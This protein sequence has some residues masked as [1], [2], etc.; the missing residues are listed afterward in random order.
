[1]LTVSRIARRL[2][3]NLIGAL[4]AALA[5]DSAQAAMLLSPTGP[6][7]F[8][9]VAVGATATKTLTLTN[10]GSA[11]VPIRGIEGLMVPGPITQTNTCGTALAANATCQI[12]LTFAPTA[13]DANIG[14]TVTM[15]LKVNADV[16]VD[17]SPY[18]LTGSISSA[19]TTGSTTPGGTDGQAMLILT[20][21]GPLAFGTVLNG[22]TETRLLNLTNMGFVDATSISV[23]ALS[24]PF[25]LRNGCGATLAPRSACT[26][27]VIY[28]PNDT[29]P[30]AAKASVTVNASVAVGGSPYAVTATSSSAG[31]VGLAF[32]PAGSFN[33]GSVKVGTTST[34]TLTLRNSAGTAATINNIPALTPPFG[35]TNNCPAKLAPGGSCQVKVSYTPTAAEFSTGVPSSTNLLVDASPAIAAYGLQGGPQTEKAILTLAPAGPFDFGN[36][37]GGQ[38]SRKTFTISNTGTETAKVTDV[39][40]EPPFSILPDSCHD[41]FVPPGQSCPIIVQYNPGGRE[42]EL[43]GPLTG[44]VEAFASTVIVNAPLTV[45][46]TA[47]GGDANLS[48]NPSGPFQFGGVRVGEIGNRVLRLS[49]YGG[50]AA[51]ITGFTGLSKPYSVSHNCSTSLRAGGFCDVTVSFAPTAADIG[52]ATSAQGTLT[53]SA[54]SAVTNSPYLFTA[55]P[56][57]AQAQT[58]TLALSPA[59]P[60]SFG[61]VPAGK[62]VTTKVTLTNSGSASAQIFGFTGLSA[63]FSVDSP[64]PTFL[65][66]GGSCEVKLTYAPLLT[67]ATGGAASASLAVAASVVVSGSPLALTATPQTSTASDT[68]TAFSFDAAR[69]VPLNIPVQSNAVTISGITRTVPVRIS[70]GT[71][72]INGQAYTADVSAARPGDTIKVRVS[73]STDYSTPVTATLKVGTVS[74]DFVVT[75]QTQTF[76]L[77]GTGISP[78][79]VVVQSTGTSSKQTLSLQLTLGDVISST[80]SSQA[81]RDGKFAASADYKLYVAA[82][83]PAGTLGLA[84][85]TFFTR[86]IK[87]NY[88]IAS[89]PLA[90]YLENVQLYSQDTAVKLDILSDLDFGLISGTEFYIGYG[91]SDGE[92]ITSKRFRAFYKVP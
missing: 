73:S 8:G 31:A 26:I 16:A 38:T 47:V 60:Y 24:A 45:T 69:G 53:V 42:V 28:A 83:T 54:S 12:S 76:V 22:Q 68:P 82:L 7:D 39:H 32:T 84:N 3:L 4:L 25:T 51:S 37:A 55:D 19:T 72:S 1:M 63:P 81:V 46:G 57:T 29:T 21:P 14:S 2:P 85:P 33:F 48:L 78:S 91:L 10:S 75:T 23:P 40:V 62:V 20:P 77:D 79:N 90:A 70:N 52:N 89:S 34:S 5:L 30:T 74:A 44:S 71:Y 50:T 88:V 36:V 80:A 11:A 15:Q 41:T 43:G 27:T 86:D 18:S 65:L 92:M 58:A 17:G 35:Q 64:C 61:S 56:R 66:P 59:G 13:A 87:A 67:D 49:N 6:L 9:K